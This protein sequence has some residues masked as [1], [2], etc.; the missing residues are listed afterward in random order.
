MRFFHMA[1]RHL[2]KP[3]IHNEFKERS[4]FVTVDPDLDLEDLKGPIEVDP[5]QNYLLEP[6][7]ASELV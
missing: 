1:L 7:D 6:D 2:L 4:K 5:R 3:E